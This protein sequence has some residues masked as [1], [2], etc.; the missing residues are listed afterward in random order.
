MD[1]VR[2]VPEARHRLSCHTSSQHLYVKHI[3]HLLGRVLRGADDAPCAPTSLTG[4]WEPHGNV[5]LMDWSQFLGRSVFD[6]GIPTPNWKY[7]PPLP[8]SD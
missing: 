2:Q 7:G 3:V 4:V 5:S 1:T 6:L 8:F